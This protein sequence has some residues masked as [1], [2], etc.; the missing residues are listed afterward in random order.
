MQE[1]VTA[2][3][4]LKQQEATEYMA[5]SHDLHR[6]LLPLHA[7]LLQGCAR[8]R[9]AAHDARARTQAR[10]HA[11]V[12]VLQA[13]CR[14]LASAARAARLR[15]AAAL[16]ARCAAAARRQDLL[17]LELV[18]RDAVVQAELDERMV[19]RAAWEDDMLTAPAVCVQRV[20]RGHRD[21][22]RARL[23]RLRRMS[24]DE[25]EVVRRLTAL[26]IAALQREEGCAREAVASAERDAWRAGAGGKWTEAVWT[27][28]ALE[29]R[30]REE[31]AREAADARAAQAR[32]LDGA[33]AAGPALPAL[34]DPPAAP[35][36]AAAVVVATP[37]T[38]GV[39]LGGLAATE[40]AGRLRVETEERE[41]HRALAGHTARVQAS[42]TLGGWPA[43]PGSPPGLAVG[44]PLVAARRRSVSGAAEPGAGDAPPLFT[45]TAWAAGSPSARPRGA[46]LDAPRSPSA[47]FPGASVSLPLGS[48]S[49]NAGH[50]GLRGS[51]GAPPRSFEAWLQKQGRSPK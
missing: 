46:A 40:A 3:L 35:R 47:A 17:A 19:L 14:A 21:R 10:A 36:P 50:G 44:S 34:P 25:E 30:E 45:R 7:A 20:A 1:Q 27:Q 15:A 33:P 9:L 16:R 26:G 11:R 5:L 22:Q 18:R 37:L 31:I 23:L 2:A 28:M 12:S 42:V 13:H 38:P 6:R 48:H 43:F 4:R 24:E 41:A 32:G 39:G 29:A 49:P 8:A 51:P